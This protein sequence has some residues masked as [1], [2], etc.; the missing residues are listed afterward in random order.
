MVAR[1]NAAQASHT[2]SPDRAECPPSG[3][4][5]QADPATPIEEILRFTRPAYSMQTWFL[6]SILASSD[7]ITAFRSLTDGLPTRPCTPI[8]YRDP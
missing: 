4:A 6:S 8:Q 2:T 5:G 3:Q 7:R 1:D